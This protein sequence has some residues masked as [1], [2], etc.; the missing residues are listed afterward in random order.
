MPWRGSVI[1]AS[2]HLAG[3]SS[4]I[5]AG[6]GAP[7]TDDT[8]TDFRRELQEQAQIAR[9]LQATHHFHGHA[10]CAACTNIGSRIV[11]AKGSADPWAPTGIRD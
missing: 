4:R 1:L 11:E 8:P 5:H 3:L 6:R 7:G 9:A 2:N 10:P